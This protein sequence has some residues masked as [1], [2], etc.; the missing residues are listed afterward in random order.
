MANQRKEIERLVDVPTRN[1]EV[2][3]LPNKSNIS[4]WQRAAL[5]SFRVLDGSGTLVKIGERVF[6]VTV[7]HVMNF[8]ASITKGKIPIN[9]DGK[10]FFMKHVKPTNSILGLDLQDPVILEFINPEDEIL[11]KETYHGVE[12]SKEKPKVNDFIFQLGYPNSWSANKTHMR[13][14]DRI[15]SHANPEDIIHPETLFNLVLSA[16]NITFIDEPQ[17]IFRTSSRS[18]SGNSGGGIFILSCETPLLIGVCEEG[19]PSETNDPQ[20]LP[21]I[22]IAE[23][24]CLSVWNMDFKIEIS[25][26]T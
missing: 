4:G 6:I 10:V 2:I 23:T 7:Q 15:N 9:R 22:P 5:C 25:K 8:L 18:G 13:T 20:N 24:G 14:M 3:L 17:S 1:H 12:I 21:V 11:V 26:N 19:D 16:G